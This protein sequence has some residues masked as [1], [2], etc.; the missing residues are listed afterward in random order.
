MLPAACPWA[1]RRNRRRPYRFWPLSRSASPWPSVTSR[2][3]ALYLIIRPTPVA[4]DAVPSKET[5]CRRMASLTRMPL[6]TLRV[7][8]VGI[9]LC[10]FH[11][12]SVDQVTLQQV[13][14]QVGNVNDADNLSIADHGKSSDMAFDHDVH[15]GHQM[16][17]AVRWSAHPGS[18][19]RPLESIRPGPA[20]HRMP[21][22]DRFRS[23]PAIHWHG[24][25]GQK[26]GYRTWRACPPV[27]RHRR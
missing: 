23:F 6:S 17:T 5:I 10:P 19:D 12:R 1:G 7:V 11:W 16:G 14:K 27:C 4:M 22:P 26:A 8:A 24:A 15:N 25:V 3:S 13:V 21:G 9:S 18:S 20:D 2:A